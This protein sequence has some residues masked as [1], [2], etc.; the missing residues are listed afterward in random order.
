MTD[1]PKKDAEIEARFWAAL[2]KDMTVMLG[3]GTEIEYRPMTAQLEDDQST[4]PIWFF[5]NRESDLV[6]HLGTGAKD[7][8]FHFV[9]KGHD[10]WATVSGTLQVEN[11]RAM[12]DKLWNSYVSAWYEG[13]KDDP[14]LALLRLDPQHAK[15]WKDGS[16]LVAYALTLLG[17]DPTKDYKDNIAEVSMR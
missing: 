16:S 3:L 9:S 17:R 1:D 12:I 8:S 13:G 14:K 2:R 4:G 5:G 7:A 11:N 10:I 15:L 6:E